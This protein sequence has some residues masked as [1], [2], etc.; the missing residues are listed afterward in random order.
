MERRPASRTAEGPPPGRLGRTD[1]GGGATR[2]AQETAPNASGSELEGA[3]G[4]KWGG[5]EVGR[6]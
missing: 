3:W 6:W 2:R 1:R 5:V 4:L